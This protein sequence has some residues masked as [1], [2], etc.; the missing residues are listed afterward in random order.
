M[1]RYQEA[2]ESYDKAIEFKPDDAS[3]W[4]NKACCYS[5]VGNVELAIE[6]LQK[7]MQLDSKYIEMAKTD[8]DFDNIRSDQRFI[9]LIQQ[10]SDQESGC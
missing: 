5:L 10:S 6:Y 4:Y 1:G 2:I 3:T 7:A 9:A 8:S